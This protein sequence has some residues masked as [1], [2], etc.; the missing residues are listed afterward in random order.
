MTKIL[1]LPKYPPMG[2]SSRMRTYQYLPLWKQ[3]GH[4]VKVSSFFN[5]A[6]LSQVY[7]LRRPGVWNVLKCYLRRFLILFTAVRYDYVWVEKELFP[8]VPAWVEAL[9]SALGLRLILDYD[10]A[11]FHNYDKSKN[12]WVRTWLPKKIDR[13]MKAAYLVLAGNRYLAQRAACAGATRIEILP[14]VI[15]LK[16]YAQPPVFGKSRMIGVGSPTPAMGSDDPGMD[17][18]VVTVGWIGSPSTL[19]Y[20]GLVSQALT[21]LYGKTPFRF[22][23]VNG[24]SVRYQQ[25]LKLPPEAVT[26]LVWSE[27]EE[28][29]QIRQMDI[30][31]MPLPD[32]PWERGK[33]AYKL[34]QYMACGLPVVASPVGMNTEVVHHGQNGYLAH[35]EEDWVEYLGRLLADAEARRS[36]G[37]EGRL[38]VEREFTLE[39]NFKKM[40]AYVSAVL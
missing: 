15:D 9:L 31:I 2:A 4:G 13:V 35:S 36:M 18:P 25:Y 6:Y 14:T 27:E 29:G 34:I 39:G 21:R 19:K 37:E 8:F 11:V 7:A 17:P 38:L 40:L 10:D 33:C 16:K 1:F 3:A 5:E 28:V 32:D 24:G 26:R 22:V 20:L 30:G 23:L 12:P